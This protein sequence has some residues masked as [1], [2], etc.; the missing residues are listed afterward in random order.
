MRSGFGWRGAGASVGSGCAQGSA[1]RG[2][3]QG[4]H[5]KIAVAIVTIQENSW[6]NPKNPIFATFGSRS[7]GEN[8]RVSL[9][10]RFPP[11]STEDLWT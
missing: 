5:L 2:G 10:N 1:H 6:K 4:R 3:G 8:S 11:N 9:P 7:S